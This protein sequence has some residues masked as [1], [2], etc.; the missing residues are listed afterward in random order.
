MRHRSEPFPIFDFPAEGVRSPCNTMSTVLPAVL[1]DVSRISAL[2]FSD[3]TH[4]LHV[5][6]FTLPAT[7]Q[8]T[9]TNDSIVIL[10]D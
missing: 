4:A 10:E 6:H 2:F 5:G 8:S 3:F 9:D 7:C 1:P